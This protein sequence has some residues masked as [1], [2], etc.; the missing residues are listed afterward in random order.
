MLV[1][2]AEK[3]LKKHKSSHELSRLPL[4]DSAV[5]TRQQLVISA[6]ILGFKDAQKNR[7]WVAFK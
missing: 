4:S 1:I 2:S 5:I 7:T 3:F 6:I